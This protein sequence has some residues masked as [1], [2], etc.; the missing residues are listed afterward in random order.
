MRDACLVQIAPQDLPVVAAEETHR[1][2]GLAERVQH[3][4]DIHALAGGVVVHFGGA[5]DLIERERIENHAPRQRRRGSQADNH[6]S[7]SVSMLIALMRNPQ[8]AYSLRAGSFSAAVS[9][10]T[11]FTPICLN[12]S[13][14]SMTSCRA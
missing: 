1:R 8:P 2:R 10:R 14:A 12:R 3:A 4:R 5:V 6:G 11:C 13:T 7:S 9:S